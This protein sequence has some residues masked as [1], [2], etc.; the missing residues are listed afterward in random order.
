MAPGPVPEAAAALLDDVAGRDVVA[1]GGGRVVDAAKAV[2]A[3]GGGKAARD[4]DHARGLNL[5]A[6]HRMPTATRATA[7]RVPRSPCAT[8]R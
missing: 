8:R 6:F 3:A 5:H 4:P 1:F 7:R 2:V